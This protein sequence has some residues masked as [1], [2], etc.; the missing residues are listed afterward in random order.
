MCSLTEVRSRRRRRKSA[1]PSW[2]ARR[3]S[4]HLPFPLPVTCS[5]K[6]GVTGNYTEG[7]RQKSTQVHQTR[8]QMGSDT[9]QPARQQEAVHAAQQ[10]AVHIAACSSWDNPASRASVPRE[11]RRA[12]ACTDSARYHE[13]C[14]FLES[15]LR[16]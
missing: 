3:G 6:I 16:T 2:C 15:P 10:K 1:R 11:T 4:D 7:S 12:T 13:P 5:G 8:P 14:T 9:H